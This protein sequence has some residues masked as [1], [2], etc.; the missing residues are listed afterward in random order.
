[1]NMEDGMN[2]RKFLAEVLAAIGRS[3]K[4]LWDILVPIIPTIVVLRFLMGIMYVLNFFRN[5][6]LGLL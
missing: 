6:M 3:I 4:N 2:Y 1:M 5:F